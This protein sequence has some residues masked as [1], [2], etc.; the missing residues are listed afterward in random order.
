MKSWFRCL[1]LCQS[2]K[3]QSRGRRGVEPLGYAKNALRDCCANLYLYIVVFK[4][5][6]HTLIR[7]LIKVVL[8]DVRRAKHGRDFSSILVNSQLR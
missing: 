6:L 4:L 5:H 1:H 2:T 7:L 3:A 8:D